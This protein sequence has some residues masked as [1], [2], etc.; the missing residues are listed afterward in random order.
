MPRV[1]TYD[2]PQ[3]AA[4][5]LP[6]TRVDAPLGADYGSQQLQQFSQAS[7]R[8]AQTAGQIAQD[9]AQKAN[10]ARIDD[11]MTQAVKADTDLRVQAL[12]LRGRDALDRP[13]SKALPDEFIEKFDA[14]VQ[15]IQA[16]LGNDA[17]KAAFRGQS[18]HLRQGLYGAL[19]MHVV[20]Q[21]QAYQEQADQ[22]KID[23]AIERAS[24][25]PADEQ[26]FAQSLGA[27]EAT[28]Q[29][30]VKRNGG[31]DEMADAEVRKM[32]DATYQSRYKAWALN[33]PLA[34]TADFQ[35]NQ[36]KIGPLM[37]NQISWDLF[38][39]SGQS[40][41]EAS[42]PW[43]AG[44]GGA[45][46]GGP[47]PAD[48]PR[49]IRN[50]NP[51]NIVRSDERWQG[52]VNGHDARFAAFATPEAGIRAGAK[53]LL[54]YQKDHG[55]DTVSGIVSRWAPATENDPDSY[56]AAVSK[57]LGVKPDDKLDLREGGVMS[58]LVAAMIHAENG[59]QPYSDAQIAAGVDAALG[60][61]PLLDAP[62]QA[63]PPQEPAWR[64]PNA[65]TGIP[66]IDNLPPAQRAQVLAQA[67]TQLR[68]DAVQARQ[69]L[70]ARIND[71]EAEYLQTG[72]AANPPSEAEFIAAYGQADGLRRYRSLQDTAALGQHLQQTKT[73]PNDDLVKMVDDALPVL[74]EEGYAERLRNHGV[75]QKAVQMTI[76][77]RQKDPIEAAFQNLAYGVTRI[78]NMANTDEVLGEM[79]HRRSAWGSIARDYGTEPAL[80]SKAEAQVFGDVLAAQQTPDKARN[81]GMIAGLF[82][83]DTMAAISRQLKDSHYSLAVGGML[84]GY[85]A[86]SGANL[87]QMYLEGKDAL[88][89]KR[90]KIDE[91]AETGTKAEIYKALDGVYQTPQGR[92]AA[93]EAALGIYAKLEADGGGSIK[94]AIDY[95]TGGIMEYHG[96][97]IARP[98]GWEENQVRDALN[99]AAPHVIEKDGG[100]FIVAGQRVSAADFAKLL[101][102][103]RLQ[104]LGQGVYTVGEGS[105]QVRRPDGSLFV[106][107]LFGVDTR[108]RAMSDTPEIKRE[109]RQ[110]GVVN[111]IAIGMGLLY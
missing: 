72:Q 27:I 110:R 60:K 17:Q 86:P 63:S 28:V 99:I 44:A 6:A 4:N 98:M 95:A 23:T 100:E 66:L 49:G 39:V 35:R 50:N 9:M 1:P 88:A 2:S 107:D 22:A 83:N 24:A 57:A 90:A 102:G 104:T 7:G 84:S 109:M 82:G 45:P 13:D 26:A 43:V 80:F 10:A 85:T 68:Q 103:M 53:N 65:V 34:A 52:E 29:A 5:T 73:L 91:Q 87:G 93:A 89:Q 92:D 19:S 64:D 79:A 76:D 12:Q 54:A 11:A 106:L 42:K 78:K 37:R 40:L 71:A 59:Q 55:L 70:D 15:G 36:G 96:G 81:L 46:T 56:I 33:D 101:P 18:A 16:G 111:D 30:R 67:H 77:A 47:W 14:A 75:L 21:Q 61:A 105:R 94:K 20:K 32:R 8:L 38:R 62:A 25:L 69:G 41:A 58:K 51:L 108:F 31:D 97:R 74:G 48:A 3:V